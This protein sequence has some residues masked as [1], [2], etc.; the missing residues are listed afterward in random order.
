MS[1][2]RGVVL[3][4]MVSGA[5]GTMGE[6][7]DDDHVS[8]DRLRH[9]LCS[10]LS[11]HWSRFAHRPWSVLTRHAAATRIRAPEA[12]GAQ[13]RMSAAILGKTS[14]LGDSGR[15]PRLSGRLRI[16]G[17][18]T[19]STMERQYHRVSRTLLGNMRNVRRERIF[20]NE[21]RV[22]HPFKGTREPHRDKS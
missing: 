7:D 16:N 22:C 4:D 2:D 21:F 1:T 20:K 13:S 11:P 14:G 6:S 17:I 3:D 12:S 15:R 19:R 5:F 10:T 8:C 9:S 18:R